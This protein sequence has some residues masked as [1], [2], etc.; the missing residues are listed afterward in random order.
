MNKMDGGVNT[1]IRVVVSGPSGAG[2]GTVIARL[3]ERL[4]TKGKIP[5]FISV[6]ATT[7]ARR[8]GEKQDKSYY[9][10]QK[11]AFEKLIA[12][13]GLLEYNCYNGEYYGTPVQPAEEA[14][15]RGDAVIFDID[16]NGGQQVRKKYSDTVRCFLI[17]SD[18]KVLEHRLR[19]RGTET[20]DKIKKRLE[21]AI[22]EYNAAKDCDYIIVNDDLESAVDELEAIIV[23]SRCRRSLREPLLQINR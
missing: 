7:R 21:T 4:K 8:R 22:V 1:G 10:I 6:S 14:Y 9:F 11:E 5:V 16:V 23:A 2:K 20:E 15:K 13:D 12:E 17:P 18:Y 19:K 3:A